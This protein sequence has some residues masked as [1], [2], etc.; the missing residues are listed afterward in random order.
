MQVLLSEAY[1][2]MTLPTHFCWTRYGTEAGEE[3]AEILDRKE[4]ERRANGGVFLWGIGNSVGRSIE[5]LVEK[6]SC[7]QV[8]FSPIK[9]APRT[10]DVRPEEVVTWTSGETMTG[11][12]YVLPKH[13]VVTSRVDPGNSRRPRYALVCFSGAPLQLCPE[14]EV[15]AFDALHNL[16]SGRRLGASQV[17]AIVYRVAR[18]HTGRTYPV[19]LIA[20]LRAP[21]FIRLKDPLR[22]EV[23]SV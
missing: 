19:T 22:R 1:E 12:S 7:P 9:S 13:S 5:L 14:P 21:Y 10:C 2:N 4:R 23:P 8:L 16:N 3:F 20:A 18:K 6:T 15:M 11:G 17:T